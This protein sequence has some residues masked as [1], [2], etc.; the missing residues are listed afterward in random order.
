M[1]NHFSI[2]AWEIPWTEV[3]GGLQSLGLQESDP[4]ES[5]P[6]LPSYSGILPDAS[7]ARMHI[8]I[9]IYALLCIDQITENLLWI[10]GTHSALCV[11]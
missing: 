11:T 6:L 2:L 8:E 10:Q 7:G 3:P 4:T 9:D 1:A 5:K